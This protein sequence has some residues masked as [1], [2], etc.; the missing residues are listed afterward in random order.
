MP[1]QTLDVKPV[2]Q[3]PVPAKV[4]TTDADPDAQPVWRDSSLE[5]E[6]GLDV[7]ELHVDVVLPLDPAPSKP[8]DGKAD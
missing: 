8:K 5:L 2:Q 4:P 3:P 7:T 1:N 6:R